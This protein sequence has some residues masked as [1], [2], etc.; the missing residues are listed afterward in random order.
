MRPLLPVHHANR[1]FPPIA[2]FSESLVKVIIEQKSGFIDVNG[3]FVIEPKYG[4]AS[5]FH[6]ALACVKIG[7]GAV[8]LIKRTA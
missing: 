8:T 3:D 1:G 4:C 7:D 6:E 5:S 2:C